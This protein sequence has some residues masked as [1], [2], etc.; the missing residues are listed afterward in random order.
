MR[1]C[2]RSI[3]AKAFAIIDEGERDKHYEDSVHADKV[4]VFFSGGL[5]RG[6]VQCMSDSEEIIS[7]MGSCVCVR[8][9]LLRLAV[10][11]GVGWGCQ[12]ARRGRRSAKS[13]TVSSLSF[14]RSYPTVVVRRGRVPP[15]EVGELFGSV[16]KD[17]TAV[18]ARSYD[19]RL[20]HLHGR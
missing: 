19:D 2:A 5:G 7:C 17:A 20:Q 12:D 18:I 11:R 9:R 15:H 16:R 13:L 14:G 8:V 10:C 3:S 4:T 6:L 1:H